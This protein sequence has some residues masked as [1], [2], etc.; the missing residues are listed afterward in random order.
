MGHIK[1]FCNKMQS[2]SV[3]LGFSR[4]RSKPLGLNSQFF[5]VGDVSPIA[6]TSMSSYSENTKRFF[7]ASDHASASVSGS[8]RMRRH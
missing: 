7:S 6:I 5:Q 2:Y 1:C 4:T 3:E 8:I